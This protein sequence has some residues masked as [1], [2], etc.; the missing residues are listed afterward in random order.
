MLRPGRIE[1][2]YF[3]VHIDGT[4]FCPR[5]EHLNSEIAVSW[6]DGVG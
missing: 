4:F 6:P 1:A 2:A 3:F 5:H